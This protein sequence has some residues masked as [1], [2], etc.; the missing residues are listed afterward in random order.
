MVPRTNAAKLNVAGLLLT[1]AGMTL[2]KT[3]G[4][5][6]YPSY[7]GPVVLVVTAVMVTLWQ[8]RWVSY[9]A[10]AVPL[11]LGIG[12]IV[13]ALMTGDFTEQLTHAN[14]TG[15]FVGSVMHV[16][17]LVAAV[18]AGVAMVTGRPAPTASRPAVP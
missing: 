7:T 6:L 18:V 15:V 8:R 5:E 12:L 3:S 10:L 1:A 2:Q 13:T 17:G 11:V 4:S 16:V 14:D 9:V